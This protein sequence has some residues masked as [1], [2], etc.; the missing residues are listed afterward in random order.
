MYYNTTNE[1]GATLKKSRRYAKTQEFKV[2]RI[3]SIHG[4]PMTAPEVHQIIGVDNW[5]IGSIRRSLTNLMDKGLIR[6]TDILRMGFWGKPNY[7]YQ[8]KTD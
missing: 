6:K 2:Y 1:T 5:P 7:C 8:I 4:C 3:L